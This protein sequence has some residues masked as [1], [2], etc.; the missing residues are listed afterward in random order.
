MTGH[1]VAA[2]QWILEEGLLNR[3]ELFTNRQPLERD[4]FSDRIASF[5]LAAF[6]GFAIQDHAATAAVSFAATVSGAVELQMVMQGP[7]QGFVAQVVG[8]FNVLSVEVQL[9]GA[10]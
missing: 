8:N 7:N 5:D 3:M 1:A 10:P 2:L 6:D 4:E 9:H